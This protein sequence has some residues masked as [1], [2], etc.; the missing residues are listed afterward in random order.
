MTAQGSSGTPNVPDW[1][2]DGNSPQTSTG[3]GSDTYTL[4]G[5][6][7]IV[8]ASIFVEDVSGSGNVIDLRWDGVSTSSYHYVD[9]SGATTSSAQQVDRITNLGG[10]FSKAFDLWFSGRGSQ[11]ISGGKLPSRGTGSDAVGWHNQSTSQPL[12][13]ITVIG[14]GSIDIAWSVYGRDIGGSGGEP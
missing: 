12:D 7:D 14:S 3:V 9:S 13:S 6:F 10:N 4:S 5:T 2:E 1:S 11:E 8:H